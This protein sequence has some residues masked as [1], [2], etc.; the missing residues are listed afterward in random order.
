MKKSS[1]Y[2]FLSILVIAFLSSCEEAFTTIKDIDFP[3]HESK[4]AVFAEL[5]QNSGSLFVSYS[6]EIDE[7]SNY[8]TIDANV[9]ILENDSLLLNLEYSDINKINLDFNKY[10][11]PGKE[12]KLIVKNDE[13]GTA[14]ST[15]I[16]PQKPEILDAKYKQD[17]I[18]TSDGYKEDKFTLQIKDNKNT[19]EYY[20]V[21]LYNIYEINGVTIENML[22]LENDFNGFGYDV[23]YSNYNGI[24][25][26]DTNFDG[27][28]ANLVFTSNYYNYNNESKMRAKVYAITKEFYDFLVTY[29][30]YYYSDGNPFAEPV[31]VTNN[32]E[33]G[34][35]LFSVSNIATFDFEIE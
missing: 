10:L 13:Y 29:S 14:T 17:G 27:N 30:Q 12:Y 25:F 2:L 22:Y 4:L 11:Q 16:M 3:E 15:Q 1:I 21:E 7:S 26:N 31:T 19:D 23:Y 35:G 18:I 34:Y 33:N 6:K 9:E 8:N 28:T 24:V 20:Y 5:N 32:I